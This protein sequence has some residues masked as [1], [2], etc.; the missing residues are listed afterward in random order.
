MG[1]R[2]RAYFVGFIVPREKSV[3]GYRELGAVEEEKLRDIVG[4]D[5]RKKKLVIEFGLVATTPR[6]EEIKQ[7]S[8][9]FNGDEIPD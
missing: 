4:N 8:E 6:Y 7:K 2:P 1:N 5:I 3:D 9:N